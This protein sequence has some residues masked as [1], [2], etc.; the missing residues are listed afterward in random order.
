MSQE[1]LL[2][3]IEE[4]LINPRKLWRMLQV[5]DATLFRILHEPSKNI[6]QR[7]SQTQVRGMCHAFVRYLRGV[8]AK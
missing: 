6:L 7:M 4:S 2:R 3:L 1:I 8:R 5:I